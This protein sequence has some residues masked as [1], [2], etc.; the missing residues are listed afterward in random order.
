MNNTLGD[1]SNH[2]F[3]QIEKLNDDSLTGD[4]LDTEIKRSDAMTKI[5][6]QIVEIGELQLKVMQHVDE[7]RYDQSQAI[8]DMLEVHS[9]KGGVSN[10]K[11]AR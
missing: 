6:K 10:E 7:Y 2:L 8:P 4:A 11:M 1:L 9:H 5:G 3:M